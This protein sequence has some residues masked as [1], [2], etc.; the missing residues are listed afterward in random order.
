MD[1]QSMRDLSLI[2]RE[3]IGNAVKHGGAKKIAIASDPDGAGWMLRIANDGA[4]FD[5]EV[6]PGPAEGH[7]GVEGMRQRARRIGAGVSFSVRNGWT[8]LDLEVKND[9]SRSH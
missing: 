3:A 5:P 7:F 6:A 2:V 9:K 8:V 1:A 4:A